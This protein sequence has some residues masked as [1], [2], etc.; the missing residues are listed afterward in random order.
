MLIGTFT[1]NYIVVSIKEETEEKA[2]Y[3]CKKSRGDDN[4]KYTVVKLKNM[5]NADKFVEYFTT[6]INKEEFLDFIECFVFDESLYFVYLN[7]KAPSLGE[8]VLKK[9]HKFI[10]RL[11][12]GK[13]I[14]NKMVYMNMPFAI[15]CNV[16]DVDKIM[17]EED[18]SIS[19]DYDFCEVD[20]IDKCTIRDVARLLL[21]IMNL[22]FRKEV[23]LNSSD[24]INEFLEYLV[25]GKYEKYIDFLYK[26]NE[27]YK[28]VKDKPEAE[29]Q[30]PR[31]R[32]Y[33][34][35]ETTKIILKKLKVVLMVGLVLGA[36]A[37]LG[38][39][40]INKM[41][42]SPVTGKS[43]ASIGEVPLK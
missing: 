18:L 13:N 7:H 5:A 17:V 2:V 28:A 43:M 23:E 11:E 21:G 8:G 4:I 10:E 36:L 27:M 33:I 38:F 35:W 29:L 32:L 42:P 25:D 9:D 16:L 34:L 40:I 22:I 24:E 31:T 12:I 20:Q 26:Y 3:I 6:N 19:F 37:Y 14:I 15:Q 39:T 41:K 30:K 1:D